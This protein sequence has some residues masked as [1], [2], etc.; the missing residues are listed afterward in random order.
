MASKKKP[1]KETGTGVKKQQTKNAVRNAKVNGTPLRETPLRETPLRDTRTATIE[2]ESHGTSPAP[3][4]TE[5]KVKGLARENMNYDYEGDMLETE[6]GLASPSLADWVRS[7]E[8]GPE[9]DRTS[10]PKAAEISAGNGFDIQAIPAISDQGSAVCAKTKKPAKA[11]GKVS[12][13]D[14]ADNNEIARLMNMVIVALGLILLLL[15]LRK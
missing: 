6:R 1:Q 8:A 13:G 7:N 12:H 11:A 4:D 10:E 9:P 2:V 5:P 14:E 15:A 3:D